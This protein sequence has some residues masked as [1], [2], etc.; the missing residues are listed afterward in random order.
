MIETFGFIFFT[1]IYKEN[2]WKKKSYKISIRV[3]VVRFDVRFDLTLKTGEVSFLHNHLL[4][5]NIFSIKQASKLIFI[6]CRSIPTKKSKQFY[7][8]ACFHRVQKCTTGLKCTILR[9]YWEYLILQISQ[10]N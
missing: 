1:H 9:Q 2:V 8:L 5:V 10:T 3:R 6:H 4:N 7:R